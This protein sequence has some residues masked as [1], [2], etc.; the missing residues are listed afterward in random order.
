[1]NHSLPSEDLKLRLLREVEATPSSPR[2]AES[3]RTAWLVAMALLASFSIFLAF[4][5]VRITGR[6]SSLVL[7]T[8][9]GTGSIAAL[10]IWAMVGRGRAMIGRASSW[11][12]AVA[13]ASPLALLVWK[14]VWSAQF[15]NGLEA[16][17]RRP[18]FKCLGLGLVLAAF[19]LAAMLFSRRGTDAVHPGRAGMAIGIGVGLGAATLVDAWCPVAYVPHLLLGHLLPLALLGGVGF[20]LGRKILAP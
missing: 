18:G 14:L 7:G 8:V 9:I 3:K 1:M 4:G 12:T 17:E 5:G 10:A 2:P 13:I 16:W 20:W 15:E 11:L 6:P 19:P